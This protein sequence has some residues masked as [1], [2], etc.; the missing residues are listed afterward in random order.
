VISWTR[1]QFS[2]LN[3]ASL[4]APALENY[5]QELSVLQRVLAGLEF[6]VYPSLMQLLEATNANPWAIEDA[7]RDNEGC[8]LFD[9]AFIQ[10]ARSVHRNLAFRKR[11]QVA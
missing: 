8:L 2:R 4:R 3:P 11:F 7:I 6:V 5:K 9:D 10:I 1:S